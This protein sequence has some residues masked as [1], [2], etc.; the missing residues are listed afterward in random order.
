MHAYENNKPDTIVIL[1]TD[2]TLRKIILN[3]SL[4]ISLLGGRNDC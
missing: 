4:I 2:W 3:E 1:S